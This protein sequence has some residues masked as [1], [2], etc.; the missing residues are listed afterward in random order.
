M[1][2]K[3][4]S[5]EKIIF[6]GEIDKIILPT[7]IGDVT[8]KEWQKPTVTS[9]KPGIITISP[10][11][12]FREKD[13]IKTGEWIS[14]SISKWVAFICEDLVKIATTIATTKINED[15]NKLKEKKAQLEKE[16]RELRKKGSLEEIENSLVKLEKINA[17][18]KLQAL[19]N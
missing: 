2:L 11:W 7:E 19:H 18:L 5:P 13:F 14:I 12:K 10:I 3:I 15:G 9:L 6:E 1:L 16:I 17:D 8:V 4:S